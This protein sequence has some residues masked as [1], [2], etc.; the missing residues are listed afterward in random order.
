MPV[1]PISRMLVPRLSSPIANESKSFG[2]ANMHLIMSGGEN[3]NCL[4]NTV[5]FVCFQM[6]HPAL[7]DQLDDPAGIQIDAE[8]DAAAELAQV[9]NRQIQPTV[10]G[11]PSISQFAPFG[12]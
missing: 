6:F 12:K 7:L 3:G 4:I 2:V 1:M 11:R 5:L 9:L 10:T 8:A